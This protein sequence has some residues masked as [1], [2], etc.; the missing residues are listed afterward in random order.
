LSCDP[1]RTIGLLYGGD[2]GAAVAAAL[3][4][5]GWR[6]VSSLDGRSAATARRCR[7]A[8]IDVLPGVADVVRTSRIVLSLVP[9][10]AAADVAALYLRHARFAPPG[11]VYVDANSVAPDLA[12]AFAEQ[13]AGH[14]I[15]FVDAAINGLAKSL[16]TGRATL[17]VS[18]AR[19][20]EIAAIF[21]PVMR[22]QVL[23]PVPGR[24][25]AMKMLLSALSK[26]ICALFAETA[27]IARRHDLL[28][29]LTE[30]AT[31]IYP[32]IMTLV[33]RMLPTYAQHAARRADEMR[34]VEQTAAAAAV[35]PCVLASV[36]ELHE[37]LASIGFDASDVSLSSII[38]QLAAAEPLASRQSDKT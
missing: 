7:E 14:G 27:L 33:E 2:M 32:G 38:E 25:S 8:G 6:I 13:L 20:G 11:A 22:V 37:R 21:A 12:A 35:E 3:V 26:G 15:D 28:P 30:A 4:P 16:L 17:F 9:P 31:R 10:S 19:A 34:A 36:R 1:T 18:G 5:R 29:E 23:G 24:A